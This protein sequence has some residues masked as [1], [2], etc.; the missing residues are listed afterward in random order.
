MKIQGKFDNYNGYILKEFDWSE[1]GIKI[2]WNKENFRVVST[3]FVPTTL[4]E[5]KLWEE[6]G[7]IA[8]FNIDIKK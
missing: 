1:M 2:C 5:G 7:Y 8:N 3:D 6:V 4:H